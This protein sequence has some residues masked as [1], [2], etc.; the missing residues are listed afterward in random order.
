MP[1]RVSIFPEAVIELRRGE[2]TSVRCWLEY[3]P[4]CA[5]LIA[6]AWV[7]S[8]AAVH[9]PTAT[10]ATDGEHGGQQA[11]LRVWQLVF[12]KMANVFQKNGKS[13]KKIRFAHQ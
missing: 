1:Q 13:K 9:Y 10:S 11:C 8:E 6:W 5:S 2:G 7:R 12:Q 3:F 4:F